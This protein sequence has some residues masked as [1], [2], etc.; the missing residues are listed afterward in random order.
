MTTALS[1]GQG[2][3]AGAMPACL[4]SSNRF[5]ASARD[6]RESYCAKLVALTDPDRRR[7]QQ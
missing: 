5:A 7:G 6:E 3:G 2:L 4:A 1:A